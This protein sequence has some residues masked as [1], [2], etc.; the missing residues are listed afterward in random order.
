[1][2]LKWWI[3]K[4]EHWQQLRISNQVTDR[5]PK[6]RD[7]LI[8]TLAFGELLQVAYI[9]QVDNLSSTGKDGISYG[10]QIRMSI[11]NQKKIFMII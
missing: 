2:R 5:L 3:G 1:M 4:V 11:K 6:E 10:N 8:V 7:Y 9:Q